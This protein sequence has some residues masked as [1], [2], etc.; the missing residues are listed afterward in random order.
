MKVILTSYYPDPKTKNGTLIP[1]QEVDLSKE[2]AES[3]IKSRG[4]KPV[5]ELAKEPKQVE[6]K[7]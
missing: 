1:G 3:L 4:A 7:R 6:E 2:V 5:P